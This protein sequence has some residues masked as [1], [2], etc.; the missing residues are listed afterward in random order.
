MATNEVVLTVEIDH[1]DAAK[2][3]ARMI[4]QF[5]GADSPL[6]WVNQII[7]AIFDWDDSYNRT[8]LMPLFFNKQVT[9]FTC[10]KNVPDPGPGIY[11]AVD[12][13]GIFLKSA[14]CK[15]RGD[16]LRKLESHLSAR[17]SRSEL[18]DLWHMAG[19]RLMF[20]FQQQL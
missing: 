3:I 2:A 15:D 18:R 20:D 8:L 10:L 1:V 16:A 7:L 9:R 19:R 13:D 4:E 5:T 11:T 17:E 6:D 12:G 14:Y